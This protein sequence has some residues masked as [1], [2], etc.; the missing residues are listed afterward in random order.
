MNVDGDGARGRIDHGVAV[1]RRLGDV[2]DADLAGGPDDILDNDGLAKSFFQLRGKQPREQV[3]ATAGR[4]R[5]HDAHRAGWKA[6]RGG[7]RC[8]QR[9]NDGKRNN[10]HTHQANTFSGAL[11]L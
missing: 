10:R 2:V 9:R 1:G 6:L 7:R 4:K 8:S 11:R 5:R 3:D